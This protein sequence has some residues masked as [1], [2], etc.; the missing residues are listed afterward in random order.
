MKAF[1]QYGIDNF[2]FEIVENA[3]DYLDM[4][5]KE[6]N[7][8][9]KE[10]CL[11]PNGYNQTDRTDSPM[12]DPAIAKKMSDTKREKYGKRVCELNNDF[13]IVNTWNSLAEAGEQTGL[14][15]YKISDVCNGRRLT[16]GDRIFRFI[17][18]NNE[19]VQPE[20]KVNQ[21]QTNR[22]TKTSKQVIKLNDNN[23][24]LQTYDSV[25][26]AAADNNCDASG[27]SKVCNGKRKKCGGFKWQYKM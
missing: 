18:Q 25:A 8:I 19:I 1:R 11:F 20:K 16:T 14:D 12:F 2:T 26:L 7:W 5:L 13:Q 9:E 4:I 17:N 22:I 6:H 15:R 3:D 21:T 23:E 10:N 24:I 27:I